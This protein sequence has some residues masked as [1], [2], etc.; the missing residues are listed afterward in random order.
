LNLSVIVPVLGDSLE[1]SG[2]LE[3]LSGLGVE[4]V[5]VDGARDASVRLAVEQSGGVWVPSEPG[6]GTQIE[7]GIATAK[8][9]WIWI[10]HADSRATANA[11][12]TLRCIVAGPPSWGR[13]NVTITGLSLVAF[14]MN[15]RSRITKIC[16]GDQAMFFHRD[17]L[18]AAGGFPRIPLMEDIELSKRLKREMP[19]A[20]RACQARVTTS[21]R[22]WKRNGVVRTVFLMWAFRVRYYLGADPVDL[23]RSYYAERR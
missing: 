21:P 22:R 1:L 16:T 9:D 3:E 14:L 13:F 6:R 7:K 4:L 17:I 19:N 5:V 8:G 15:W 23:Y 11:I 18:D 20:F 2:L 10:L 12:E